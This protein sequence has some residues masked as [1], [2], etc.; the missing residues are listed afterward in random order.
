MA[1]CRYHWQQGLRGASSLR[2]SWLSLF[3]VAQAGVALGAIQGVSQGVAA[4][5]A[6]YH[7]AKGIGSMWTQGTLNG[8]EWG[9]AAKYV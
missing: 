4:G 8:H 6:G 7:A 1:C 3:L 5:L 9:Q 2:W